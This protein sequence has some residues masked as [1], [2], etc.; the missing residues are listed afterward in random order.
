METMATGDNT[1]YKSLLL[2]Y[3]DFAD[4]VMNR[5]PGAGSQGD[6]L[7]SNVDLLISSYHMKDHDDDS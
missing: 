6:I 7:P 1:Q 5:L 2:K 3:D 4:D